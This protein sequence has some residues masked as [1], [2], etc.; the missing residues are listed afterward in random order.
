ML[1]TSLL[2]VVLQ[3]EPHSTMHLLVV[4]AVDRFPREQFQAAL[5]RR[6][7][8]QWAVAVL[9]RLPA[10]IQEAT[11]E[12]QHLQSP[13]EPLSRLLPAVAVGL[14]S[15]L[16]ADFRPQPPDGLVA[17]A[18]HGR[19]RSQM[20]QPAQVAQDSRAAMLKAMATLLSTKQVVA[21]AAPVAQA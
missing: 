6:T 18:D 17:A 11:A 10:L 14:R 16:V 9:L 3:V 2:R 5:H 21:V 13:Q 4:A 20:A 12:H 7:P 8:S 1:T 19:H 15:L